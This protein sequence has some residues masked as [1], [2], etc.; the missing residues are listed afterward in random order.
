MDR[1]RPQNA[2]AQR[3]PAL[4]A[5]GG[6]LFETRLSL[7]HGP[8]GDDARAGLYFLLALRGGEPV[9][10]GQGALEKERCTRFALCKAKNECADQL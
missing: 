7:H 4:N 10:A 1:T 2:A 9:P 6:T 5:A 3:P 8:R